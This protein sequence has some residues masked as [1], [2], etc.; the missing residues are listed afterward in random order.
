[1]CVCVCVLM[2]ADWLSFL[3]LVVSRGES[4]LLLTLMRVP[5]SSSAPAASRSSSAASFGRFPLA[6][7]LSCSACMSVYRRLLIVPR[8]ECTA[9]KFALSCLASSTPPQTA[10]QQLIALWQMRSAANS[11]PLLPV[12]MGVD[13]ELV[14]LLLSHASSSLLP[15]L[16]HSPLFALL[17]RHLVRSFQLASPAERRLNV[18]SG[19]LPHACALLVAEQMYSHACAIMQQATRTSAES[20]SSSSSGG[21]TSMQALKSLL[22][23]AK[24]VLQQRR[25]AISQEQ[26]EERATLE[27]ELN[28]YRV[29]LSTLLMDEFGA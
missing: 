26:T 12:A 25:D 27:V 16:P 2:C 18:S 21:G 23:Q 3:L 5:P 29:A 7:V 1:M 15:L 20:S 6:S 13:D 4:A 17:A 10:V 14:S 11:H 8:A 24:S 9:F 19:S 22:Q 28:Q